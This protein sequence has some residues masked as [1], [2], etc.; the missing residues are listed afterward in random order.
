MAYTKHGCLKPFTL[1]NLAPTQTATHEF[2]RNCTTG[3]LCF[4]V[5]LYCT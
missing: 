3:I 2:Q 5:F 1:S 4:I